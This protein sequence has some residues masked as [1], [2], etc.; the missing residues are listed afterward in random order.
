VP[1]PFEG[2]ESSEGSAFL[3]RLCIPLKALHSFELS[4][5]NY[6]GAQSH[7]TE[8]SDSIM[9][10]NYLRWKH[11]QLQNVMYINIIYTVLRSLR[12]RQSVTYLERFCL[13]QNWT[14]Y[15]SKDTSAAHKLA[16]VQS[17][18]GC[19]PSICCLVTK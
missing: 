2:R 16:W 14:R 5:T 6:T 10:T 8:E 4:G 18:D 12:S 15:I 19:P 7:N 13:V 1:I 3:W 9:T 11:G 17:S